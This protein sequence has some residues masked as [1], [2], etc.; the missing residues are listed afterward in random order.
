MTKENEKLGV[1]IDS[2]EWGENNYLKDLEYER[3]KQDEK[4]KALEEELQTKKKQLQ[5]L[6]FKLDEYVKEY[7]DFKPEKK[8][9]PEPQPEPKA[10]KEEKGK[11]NDKS[12]PAE[13]LKKKKSTG[14]EGPMPKL[15]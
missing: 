8:K 3:K 13:E 15:E 5:Q 2:L 12:P 1:E 6:T 7:P 10:K 4:N 14:V 9:K 11:K